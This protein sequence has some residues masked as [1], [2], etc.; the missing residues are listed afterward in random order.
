VSY[1]IWRNLVQFCGGTLKRHFGKMLTIFTTGLK[2]SESP[3]VQVESVKAIGAMVEFLQHDKEVEIVGGVIP[4]MVEVIEQCLKKGDEQNVCDG[5]EVFIELVESRVPVLKKHGVE[6][7][8]F[9]MRIASAKDKLPMTVRKQAVNYMT[10]M[11]KSKPKLVLKYDL[12]QQFLA[13]CVNLVMESENIEESQVKEED[14]KNNEGPEFVTPLGVACDLMD[15][16]FL[17]IPSEVC[18]PLAVKVEKANKQSYTHVY[19]D[20]AIQ[21]LVNEENSKRR[22]SAYVMMAMMVEGCNQIIMKGDNLAILLKAAIKGIKDED[23]YCRKC[24]FEALSQFCTH[25][26]EEMI[27]FHKMILPEVFKS[28][29]RENEEVRVRERALNTIELFVDC[30]NDCDEEDTD[31]KIEDYLEPIMNTIREK[32]SSET[33]TKL[34]YKKIKQGK[35]LATKNKTLQVQAVATLASTASSAGSAFVKYLPQ[36]LKLLEQLLQIT[37]KKQ[38]ELRAEATQCLGAVAIA[39]GREH[40]GPHFA[41]YH[42]FIMNGVKEFDDSSLREA[43]FMYFSELA[44]VMGSEIFNLDSFDDM[45][46]LCL[47]TMADD[48]GL[49]VEMPD[50]GFSEAVPKGFLDAQD[51]LEKQQLEALEDDEELDGAKLEEL[52]DE[53]LQK[54]INQAVNDEDEEAE[55][56][57]EDDDDLDEAVGQMRSVKLNVTT[58]FME[59]KAAAIHSISQFIAHGKFGFLNYVDDVWEQILYLWEYPHSLVKLALSHCVHELLVLITRFS[60]MEKPHDVEENT[61]IW[62]YKWTQGNDEYEW[63]PRVEEWIDKIFPLYIQAIHDE[64]DKDTLASMLDSFNTQLKMLGPRSVKKHMEAL[65]TAINNFYNEKTAC[66][67]SSDVENEETEDVTTKH[68]FVTDVV[69]ETLGML[70]ELWGEKFLPLFEKVYPVILKWAKQ[71]RHPHDQAMAVGCI[72][73]V[74]IRLVSLKTGPMTKFADSAFKTALRVAQSQE[75]N[76]RQNALYC[77]GALFLTCSQEANLKHSQNCLRCVNTYMKFP[78]DGSHGEQ[79]TRDNAVSALGKMMMAESDSLPCDKL[80]PAFLQSLPLTAD[81]SEYHW[82]YKVLI[83]FVTKEKEKVKLCYLFFSLNIQ[84]HRFRYFQYYC[85]LQTLSI[86]ANG[87][88]DDNVPDSAKENISSCLQDLCKDKSI[89]QVVQTQVPEAQ[90]Q[91]IVRACQPSQQ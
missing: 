69:A 23:A 78:K 39:A 68:K 87:I 89:Q 47:V 53:E 60:L 43:T 22:K 35:C 44:E 46:S 80:L 34:L 61:D 88:Q 51:K 52:D 9:M 5:I 73:D 54:L 56:D 84:H 1:T 65:M 91:I 62:T 30:F 10:W 19:G 16:I 25:A 31:F 49:A 74:A 70:A 36:V 86:F 50:D 63:G 37:D 72:A 3:K 38:L 13:L 82:V 8:K 77:I 18:F 90:R 26:S 28:F 58:G 59:E 32:S 41:K 42:A 64:D 7:T 83:H 75:N 66:H 55:D 24:A 17:N 71:N 67:A 11:C 15:E 57:E 12:V 33:Y 20:T 27:G 40:Y 48:D 21:Q 81:F 14:V 79:L 6:L 85:L 76:T 45:F 4:Q 2:D 29:E